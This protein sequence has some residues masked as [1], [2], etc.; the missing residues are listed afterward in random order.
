MMISALPPA[1]AAAGCA[2]P[3]S[4]AVTVT[5]ALTSR[6]P[7]GRYG[8][9]L[10]STENP[11]RPVI[12]CSSRAASQRR[13]NPRP[14]AD[15][16]RHVDQLDPP[17]GNQVSERPVAA[18]QPEA[19]RPFVRLVPEDALRAART[20]PWRCGDSRNPVQRGPQDLHC[21]L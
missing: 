16:V 20:A 1:G 7:T 6:P 8:F 19:Q 17:L 15:A 5:I 13:L 9:W 10:M 21:E 18:L 14:G 11:G 3:L 12:A 4:S 2:S